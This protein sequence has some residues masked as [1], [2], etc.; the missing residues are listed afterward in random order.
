MLC[1]LL[2][3]PPSASLGYPSN[4]PSSSPL[5]DDQSSQKSFHITFRNPSFFRFPASWTF[6]K[7]C[8][9][10]SASAL[11]SCSS[12]LIFPTSLSPLEGVLHSVICFIMF[13]EPKISMI[14]RALSDA[15]LGECSRELCPLDPPDST[16]PPA[17]L[18]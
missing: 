16:P 4:L 7:M 9:L 11:Y 5:S 17:A 13:L 12:F 15:P 1:V 10:A 3:Q 14:M 2:I 6:L 8:G 18:R